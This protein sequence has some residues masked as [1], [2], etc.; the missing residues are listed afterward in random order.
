MIT[1]ILVPVDGSAH[2]AKAVAF[3]SELAYK[4]GLA[5]TLL[6]V[7]SDPDRLMAEAADAGVPD[8]LWSS[9]EPEDSHDHLDRLGAAANQILDEAER[10]AREAGLVEIGRAMEAGETAEQIVDHAK[11][12]NID[13][14]VM[15]SRGLSDL[16]SLFL[17]SVTHKVLQLC[18]CPCVA[19]K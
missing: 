13:L 7:I 11:R 1:N 10:V 3:A 12:H 16:E 2:A 5:V 8:D 15:G 18:D 19:V 14:I 4:L 6:H 9:P 17:G